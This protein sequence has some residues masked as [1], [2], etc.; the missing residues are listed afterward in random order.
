ML[1]HDLHPH[2]SPGFSPARKQKVKGQRCGGPHGL[3]H[4][5]QITASALFC[6][7]GKPAHFHFLCARVSTS[8]TQSQPPVP[9]TASAVSPTD[10]GKREGDLVGSV[11]TLRL[12][13]ARPI[14]RVGRASGRPKQPLGLSSDRVAGPCS[15]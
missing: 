7:G 14:G 1:S 10:A 15:G 8:Y 11:G 5:A 4:V 12:T 13:G 2:Q 3:F 9:P 6:S